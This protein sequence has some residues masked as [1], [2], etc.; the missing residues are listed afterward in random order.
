MYLKSILKSFS[1]ILL[2]VMIVA[3]FLTGCDLIYKKEPV[4]LYATNP[5]GNEVTT[6]SIVNPDATLTTPFT[7]PDN[8]VFV[9]TDMDIS[10]ADA[11]PN[12]AV[13]VQLLMFGGD[14]L[15]PFQDTTLADAGGEGGLHASLVTGVE[16]GP[17]TLF[18]VRAT[19]GTG[20]N[21]GG[22]VVSLHGYLK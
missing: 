9:V 4:T 12:A 2:A 5:G 11:A 21:P 17:N 8:R 13:Y 20:L 7:I 22:V 10:F 19:S 18:G 14:T 6:F 3:A 16:I 15:A 1:F